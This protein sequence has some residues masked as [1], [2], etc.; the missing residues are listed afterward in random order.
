MQN[1]SFRKLSLLMIAVVSFVFITTVCSAESVEIRGNVLDTGENPSIEWNAVN[2][3]ALYIGMNEVGSNAESLYYQNIDSENPAIGAG[4]KNNV[5]DKKELIYNTHPY[6][7]R[8]KLSSKTDASVVSTYSVIPMFGEKYIT[9]KNDISKLTN[10]ITEQ[11]GGSEK[12]LKD[13]ESWNLG[14]GYSLKL[15][16]LDTDGGKAFVALYKDGKELDS[17]VLDIDGTDDE[18]SFIVKD[19]FAGLDNAV[20]FVTYI[21]QSFMCSSECFAIFKY[22]WLLDKDNVTTLEEGDRFGLLKCREIS[23]NWI[24]MSNHE[25]LTLEMNDKTYF[26]D[27]WYFKTSKS[28]KGTDGGY[29]LYP[30]ESKTFE[31]VDEDKPSSSEDSEDKTRETGSQDDKITRDDKSSDNPSSTRSNDESQSSAVDDGSEKGSIPAED[32][33]TLSTLPGFSSIATIS[34]IL[35]VFYVLKSRAD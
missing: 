29:L 3:S 14:K 16:Q 27:D 24:N 31:T 30:A 19:D 18:K 9:V 4:S 10:L 1:E 17:D 15:N 28:G 11:G 20:Y 22:T 5:I 23:D 6:S 33:Q 35:T 7:K 8:F 2:W 25:K 26:T 21:D 12:K 13:G 32:K 34:G